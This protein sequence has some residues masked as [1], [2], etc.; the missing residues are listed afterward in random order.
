MEN[1]TFKKALITGAGGFVGGRLA[2]FLAK[3]GIEINAMHRPGSVLSSEL[4]THA[5]IHS[6]PAELS[7]LNS[8]INAS[9]DCDVIFHLAAYAQP[10]A[11]N[12]QTYYE[13]NVNGTINVLEAAK[14]CNVKRIVVTATAGTFGP[15]VD[16]SLITEEI[17]QTLPPFTE[18]ERTKK[19]ANEKIQDYVATGMDIVTVSPTRIFGPG[20][21]SAS[22]SVTI[23]LEKYM[24]HGF[25]FLPGDGRTTGNYAYIKD[26]VNG[27]YLAA[28]KGKSGENYILGGENL[29]YRELLTAFGKATGIKRK[30]FPVPLFMML[31]AANTM[32]FLGDKFNIKPAITPPF[33]RKYMHTWATDISKAKR[34]LGYSITPFHQ[35]IK[36]TAN[37]IKKENANKN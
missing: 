19:I 22:N 24:Y 17:H 12:I 20:N 2:L 11:K 35:A 15:Q 4:T 32:Q 37:W 6:T 36:E 8:L 26:M 21:L 5:N 28:I 34:E 27:L 18:Y 9:K 30:Q 10:W 13:V 3:K 33:I 23:L 25:R 16:D 7:D 14:A 31:G 29:T 1:T